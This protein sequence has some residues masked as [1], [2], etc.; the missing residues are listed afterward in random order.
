M[1]WRRAL[2]IVGLHEWLDVGVTVGAMKPGAR[3]RLS[4]AMVRPASG[5]SSRSEDALDPISEMAT[6]PETGG[7]AVCVDDHGAGDQ[8]VRHRTAS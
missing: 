3:I 7:A 2:S 4:A 8:Q 5:R 1:P 6:E